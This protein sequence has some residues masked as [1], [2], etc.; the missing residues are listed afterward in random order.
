MQLGC[1]ALLSGGG[2][3]AARDR[4][5]VDV[6][7]GTCTECKRTNGETGMV[8]VPDCFAIVPSSAPPGYRKDRVTRSEPL[9]LSLARGP[10]VN[11][12]PSRNPENSLN[13]VIAKVA[14]SL[15]RS[16]RQ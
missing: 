12:M 14:N 1:A 16:A 15:P 4:L 2:A 9:S 13:P 8:G 7:E 10:E 3:S 6:D 5:R 11:V